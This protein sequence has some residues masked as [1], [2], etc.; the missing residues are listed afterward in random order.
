VSRT[1]L[2]AT[3]VS[4]MLAPLVTA[5]AATRIEQKK[6][7]D[8]SIVLKA[9]G[10]RFRVNMF[11]QRGGLGA[12][13]RAIR[14]TIP[15]LEDLG[16]PPAV[17]S[18]TA[19]RTGLVLV[20]GATASGK[21]TTLAAFIDHIN[22]HEP[23][24]I[25][26][27]EDPVEILHAH[28]KALVQQRE[29]GAHTRSFSRALRSALREDPDVIVI[30]EM[31]DKETAQLALTAAET[32]HLVLATLNTHSA[33]RTINRVIGEFP[34]AQQG[35]VRAML[36]ESLRAIVSQRLLPRADGAG[37][38]A[39]TEVLMSTP[40]VANLIRENRAHQLKTTM[41]TGAALGMQTLDASLQDL[42]VR[43]LVSVEEARRHAEDPRAIG[44]HGFAPPPPTVP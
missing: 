23:R 8:F 21:S 36:S 44:G 29:L 24:H 38:V 25:I 41:Q 6:D 10:H 33:V 7:A 27:L 2:S 31:R 20:G 16:L 1:A 5:Q 39:A 4:A 12:V 13:F 9:S 18:L 34:P 30:G 28:H 15:V 22:R 17:L 42:V 35:N 40:A 19:M 14:S 11:R 43:G 3:R 26:S 32:G 37:V